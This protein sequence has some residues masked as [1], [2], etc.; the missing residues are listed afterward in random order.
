M[1]TLLAAEKHRL[2]AAK[3]AVTRE[4]FDRAWDDCYERMVKEHAW[5]HNTKR[6]RGVRLEMWALRGEIREAF[7]DRRT[8]F[9][10]AAGRVREIAAGM[11]HEVPVEQLGVALLAAAAY[12][13]I[14]D[15]DAAE[16]A[17]MN[18]SA[19]LGAHAP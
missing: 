11:C 19:L 18:A 10:F 13:E 5:A 17:S 6:R 3:G 1:V 14:T 7:L 2:L 12:V 16:R 15:E 9:A 8:A 4:D